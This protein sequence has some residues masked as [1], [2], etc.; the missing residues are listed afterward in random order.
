MEGVFYGAKAFNQPLTNWNTSKVT[1]MS[2]M[3]GNAT[4]FN[5]PLDHFDTSQVTNMRG[6]FN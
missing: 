5:Q 4:V 3:F 1:N 2:R 6:M